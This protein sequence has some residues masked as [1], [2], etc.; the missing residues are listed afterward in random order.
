M[1]MIGEQPDNLARAVSRGYGLTVSV[2]KLGTL[3]QDL[4]QALRRLLTEPSFSANAARIS[5]TMR[6]HR[7]TPAEKAAGKAVETKRKEKTTPFGVN[8]LA[9]AAIS[10][11]SSATR[12]FGMPGTARGLDFLNGLGHPAVVDT[13]IM[14][15]RR[16]RCSVWS[17]VAQFTA[18]LRCLVSIAGVQK[19]TRH[20][21]RDP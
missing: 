12:Q 2:K 15:L 20:V 10:A 14:C 4:E 6:A 9:H 19:L 5:H 1:A 11:H 16:W 17:N 13:C 21:S 8:C 3:A 7:L 18:D